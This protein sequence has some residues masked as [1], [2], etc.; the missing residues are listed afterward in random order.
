M[1]EIACPSDCV[2][3]SEGQRYQ[4]E[5]KYSRLS[6]E[7]DPLRQREI[8]ALSRRF[9]DLF[10]SFENYVA[11]NRRVLQDDRR[12]LD[13]LNSVEKSLQTEQK[14]IIYRPP[15]ADLG[16]EAIAREIQ[17]MIEKRRTQAEAGLER[18]TSGDALAILGVLKDD[19]A[20]HMRS[21]T[22]Y[23]DFVARA[24]PEQRDASRLILP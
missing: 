18:L 3:L 4:V 19:I 9:G 21:G 24:H 13:A 7:W 14:G 22:R 17:E 6:R 1:V 2:F 5:Q 8:V 10:Q 11:K 16:V 20:F 23:L 15:A 12:L